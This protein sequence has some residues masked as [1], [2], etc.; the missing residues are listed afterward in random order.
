V[1]DLRS[2]MIDLFRDLGAVHHQ[3]GKLYPYREA[4]VGTS[5]WELVNALK[6]L[7]DPQHLMNPGAL[8]LDPVSTPYTDAD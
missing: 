2:R 4:L 7:L 5:S 8:S 1:I 6:A 3:I